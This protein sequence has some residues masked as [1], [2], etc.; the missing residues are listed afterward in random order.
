MK[1]Y[2]EFPDLANFYLEDSYVLDI[3]ETE[4]SITFVLDAVLTPGHPSYA[5]PPPDEQHRYVTARLTLAGASE[6]RWLRRSPRAYRDAT[7]ETDL[8]NVDRL[9]LEDDHYEA[10]GD[11]G[12]VWVFTTSPPSLDITGS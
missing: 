1:N 9:V 11:W 7:G 6:I 2:V 3:Q 4:G 5:E 10:T 12:E 8:G